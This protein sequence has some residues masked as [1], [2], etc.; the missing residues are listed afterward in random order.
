[1]R[2]VSNWYYILAVSLIAGLLSGCS[3][4]PNVRKQKD[5]QSGQRYFEKGQYSSAAI[6]FTN[7]VK[8]DP[9]YADAHYQ[10]AE[11]YLHLEQRDRAYQE[12]ART[13]ELRP[14]D[15]K[16]R[17]EMANLLILG[18]SFA[19]AQEQVDLLLKQRANDPSVHAVASSLMAM[20][21]NIPG[22]IGEMEIGRAHV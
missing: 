10:L 12:L 3:F 2:A 18:H 19:K 8:I 5:F 6:E 22:A 13:V 20:Q 17:I 1:M 16:A 11:A 21:S 15:Y 4:N 9:G 14:G 7:A